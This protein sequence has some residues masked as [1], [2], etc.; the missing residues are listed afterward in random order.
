[1]CG[2]GEGRHGKSDGRIGMPSKESSRPPSLPQSRVSYT[3]SLISSAFHKCF[4]EKLEYFFASVIQAVISR[5]YIGRSGP[6][7]VSDASMRGHVLQLSFNCTEGVG[8]YPNSDQREG[9]CMACNL[10]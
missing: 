6:F 2:G 8:G 7:A 4:P 5:R 9:V 1:M 10:Y 3:I